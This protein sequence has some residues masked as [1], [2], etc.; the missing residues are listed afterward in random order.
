MA[1]RIGVSEAPGDTP[2]EVASSI[3]R[4]ISELSEQPPWQRS[5]SPAT[6]EAE[7]LTGLYVRAAYAPIPPEPRHARRAIRLWQLLRPRLW[8]ALLLR[9]SRRLTRY[10]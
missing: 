9:W 10:R 7:E 6:E 1:R 5:L 3:E 8:L 4:Q 2:Y